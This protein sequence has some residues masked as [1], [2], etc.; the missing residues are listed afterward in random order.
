VSVKGHGQIARIELPKLADGDAGLADVRIAAGDPEVTN[1]FQGGKFGGTK[2]MRYALTPLKQ[3][4]FT[5]PALKFAYFDPTTGRYQTK[6][7][8]PIKVSVA[9]GLQAGRVAINSAVFADNDAVALGIDGLKSYRREWDDELKTFREH[10]VKDWA[11]HIGSAWRCLGLSWREEQAAAPEK[12]KPQE[13]IYTAMPDGSVRSN[14]S[15]R[16]AVEAMVR[17]KRGEGWITTT[18]PPSR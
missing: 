5:I 4:E 13:L 18:P 17:R 6:H 7:S 8:A 9:D 15:V 14:I 1:S 3:G 11:E 12:P 10:P 16:E 2:L